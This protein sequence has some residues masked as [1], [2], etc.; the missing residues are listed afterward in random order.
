MVK[1]N[2]ELSGK[3]QGDPERAAQVMIDLVE[4]RF[5]HPIPVRLALGSDACDNIRN[6]YKE[7]LE[8][9]EKWA[10]ISRS[11]DFPKET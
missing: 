10:E 8:V 2:Q 6:T 9:L 3:Q 11:T 5:K 7:N 4:K 1:Y